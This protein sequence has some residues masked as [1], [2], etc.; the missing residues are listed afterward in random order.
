MKVIGRKIE[1]MD[2]EYNIGL[3]EIYIEEIG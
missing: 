1:E 2:M 3:M